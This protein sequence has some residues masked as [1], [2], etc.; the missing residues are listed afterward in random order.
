MWRIGLEVQ[1]AGVAEGMHRL[2]DVAQLPGLEELS[3]RQWQI[4]TMLLQGERVPAIARSLY[5]GQSTVRSHLAAMFR[6]LGVHS[7]AE[8]IALFRD[9]N[10]RNV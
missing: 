3:T 9:P 5:V 6:K 1:A 2:P 10:Q 8:L 4:L 7:Q